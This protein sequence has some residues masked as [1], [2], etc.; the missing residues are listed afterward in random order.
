MQPSEGKTLVM[1]IVNV[2]P[3]SFSDG[4]RYD[5]PDRAVAHAI[6]LLEE[7]ADIIDIGAESTRPTAD[8][9]DA[10]TEW[11]RLEPVLRRLTQEPGVT[12]SI[13]TYKAEIAARALDLGVH[14]VND[15]WGGLPIT[16]CSGSSPMRAAHIFGCITAKR[17]LP[18]TVWKFFWPRHSRA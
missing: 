15:V 7:G 10:A 13:D 16:T 5:E 6:A 12:I 1:G 18:A 14:I 9:V 4:G 2:T 11:Q 3:D 8:R 17:R